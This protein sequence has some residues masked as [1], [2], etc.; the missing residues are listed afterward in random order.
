MYLTVKIRAR[1]HFT[2]RTPGASGNTTE[3]ENMLLK[4]NDMWL[5]YTTGHSPLRA[6]RE[7]QERLMVD[8]GGFMSA[9]RARVDPEQAAAAAAA[10]EM[11]PELETL[12]DPPGAL[13]RTDDTLL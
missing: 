6:I 11:T 7:E 13:K 5:P 8:Q 3:M 10:L 1:F 9:K 2:F 4:G 12:E